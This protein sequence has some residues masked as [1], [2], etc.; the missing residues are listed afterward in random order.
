[1]TRDIR[2]CEVGRAQYTVWC[3]EK[4]FVL[5]DGVVLHV[6]EDEYLLS[7]AGPDLDHLI[8][9]GDG[10]NVEI[11]DLSTDYGILAIQGPHAGEVIE[12]LGLSPGEL[13]YFDVVTTSVGDTNV[14]LS[15][16]G[17]TGDLG[18]ELWIPEG[19][20]EKVWD[21]IVAAGA[22]FNI[23]PYGISAMNMA[24]TEA[25]MTQLNVDFV[26]A[27]HAWI[28]ADRETP[29]E[30]GL[31]WMLRGLDGDDRDFIGR[32]ALEAELA[33]GSS[34]WKTVGFEVDIDSYESIYNDLGL[35]APKD[36]VLVLNT[37]SLYSGPWETDDPAAWVG[38][39]TSFMYSP[40]LKRHIGLAKLEPERTEPGALAYLE[41]AIAHK[42]RYV[43]VRVAET[44]FF[45]PD[46]K[47]AK[48]EVSP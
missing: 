37:M 39:A 20:A 6:A 15:R 13:D 2:R 41:L 47:T 5:E 18:F 44:P 43:Q 38:Y 9:R 27:R 34:R 48:V 23:I 25:G 33:S 30:L 46:R 35:I 28:G 32:D 12:S 17:Y 8:R 16:T 40:L 11:T 42:P 1:M 36:G 21:A 22:P 7:V 45:A 26:S 29:L 4:G 10:L 24:R 19:D 31:G 14:I 3:D